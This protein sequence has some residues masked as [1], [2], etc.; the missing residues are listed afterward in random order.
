MKNLMMAT[1]GRNVYFSVT[2]KYNIYPASCVF[3]CTPFLVDSV[4]L[5]VYPNALL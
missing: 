1:T 3:D 4:L 2:K 5:N